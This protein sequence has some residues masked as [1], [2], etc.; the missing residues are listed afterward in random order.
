LSNYQST[1]IVV[2]ALLKNVLHCVIIITRSAFFYYF[3][4]EKKKD[5]INLT[6]VHRSMDKEIICRYFGQL[7]SFVNQKLTLKVCQLVIA[8][9]MKDPFDDGCF[10]FCLFRS[11]TNE[12]TVP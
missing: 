5:K 1:I 7:L 3:N 4:D 6:S 10:M 8:N 2:V 11:G 9:L 12:R